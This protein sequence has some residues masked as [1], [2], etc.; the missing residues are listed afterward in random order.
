MR[1]N[2]NNL[3]LRLMA[4]R[5]IPSK[6]Y[7]VCY[8]LLLIS[9]TDTSIIHKKGNYKVPSVFTGTI[10]TWG[11]NEFISFEDLYDEKKGFVKEDSI[12]LAAVVKVF[13]FPVK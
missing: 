2:N 1:K 4:N 8:E 12:L 10:W 11:F 7:R 9:H 5:S 3:E 6:P 13:P